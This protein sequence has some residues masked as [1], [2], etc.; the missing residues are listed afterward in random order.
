VGG[1]NGMPAA[2]PITIQAF[3]AYL[4]CRTKFYLLDRP[5]APQPLFFTDTSA[6]IDANYKAAAIVQMRA[7]SDCEVID[8]EDVKVKKL[9]DRT[10]MFVD[11]Q[12]CCYLPSILFQTFEK[13]RSDWPL[14]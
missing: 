4:R 8:F 11:C 12:H 13:N 5:T 7:L 2:L 9:A 6:R 3:D 1:G 10:L 14:R